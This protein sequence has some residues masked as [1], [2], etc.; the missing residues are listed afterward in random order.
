MLRKCGRLPEGEINL[1]LRASAQ[2]GGP[3]IGYDADD[4][5]TRP[6]PPSEPNFLT[7]RTG[8]RK[9]SLD[10]SAIHYGYARRL[11]RVSGTKASS[12]GN[13]YTEHVEIIW[14]DRA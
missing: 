4:L 8:V 5:R 7:N 9:I 13:L 3:A 12:L 10:E 2:I 6:V 1:R 14:R 11:P